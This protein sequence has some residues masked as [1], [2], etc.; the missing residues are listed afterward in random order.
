MKNV[1]CLSILVFLAV[2]TAFAYPLDDYERTGIS[3]LEGYYLSQKTPSGSKS[4]PAG[5]LLNAKQVKLR[6]LE[7]DFKL[8]SVD[9]AFSSRTSRRGSFDV[10][11]CHS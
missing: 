2:S 5:A 7:T 10:W 8:P 4:F 6:L 1:L 11:N 3:R 9:A